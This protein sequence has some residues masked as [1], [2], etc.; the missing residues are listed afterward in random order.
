MGGE[1]LEMP[2][3]PGED[4]LATV[5]ADIHYYFA[6]PDHLVP[7]TSRFEKGSYVYLLY[8]RKSRAT[9]IEI[10]NALGTPDHDYFT[11]S[12]RSSYLES[13][14][15]F[16]TRCTINV[17]PDAPADDDTPQQRPCTQE[18]LLST[19]AVQEHSPSLRLRSLDLYFWTI[20][21]AMEF[22]TA[23]KRVLHPL[24][25]NFEPLDAQIKEDSKRQTVEKLEE[26]VVGCPGEP[27]RLTASPSVYG[28]SPP[29]SHY[30][31]SFEHGVGLQP[32]YQ[33]PHDLVDAP[34]IVEPEPVVY[35]PTTPMD[36]ES[37]NPHAPCQSFSD[38]DPDPDLDLSNYGHLFS[39]FSMACPPVPH[40][41]T[42][43]YF[44]PPPTG[45]VS[46]DASH[47]ATATSPIPVPNNSYSFLDMSPPPM[48]QD[49]GSPFSASAAPSTPPRTQSRSQPSKRM[50][51][52][53]RPPDTPAHLYRAPTYEQKRNASAPLLSNRFSI[54]GVSQ[55]RSYYSVPRPEPLP[56]L[57]QGVMSPQRISSRHNSSTPT[58]PQSSNRPFSKPTRFGLNSGDL[59]L[60][61]YM[62]SQ[63]TSSRTLPVNG[64]DA[65]ER[66]WRKKTY[67]RENGK[68]KT[69]SKR[70]SISD[71]FDWFISRLEKV[72][73]S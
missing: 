10:A 17:C 42:N 21:Y 70:L 40:E 56:P 51:L 25:I 35:S 48:I 9:R 30:A 54:D 32:P 62:Q 57:Q 49:P 34:M 55:T 26:I 22:Y 67:P 72:S 37:Y 47:D 59:N 5:A 63:Q 3:L 46:A 68:K 2:Q 73:G 1:E 69:K 61:S 27:Q 66:G 6:S 20:D 31:Q 14:L 43:P 44:W 41:A 8:N 36:M 60:R 15:E 58:P 18:W 52:S 28:A 13:K 33:P 38:Q 39:G 12:L 71:T 64:D 11:A 53:P 65:P 23:S 16:P 7:A 45:D 29:R 50:V 24:Q 4:S 19:G